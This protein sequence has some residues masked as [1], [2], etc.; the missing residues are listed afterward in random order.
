MSESTKKH[1]AT[2][3]KQLSFAVFVCSTSRYQEAQ[4]REK[5]ADVSGDTIE[6]SLKNAG[7]KVLSRKII[8]DDKSMI[9]EAVHSVLTSAELDAAVFC[10]GTG[11]AQKDIT[12]ETVSPFFE[13]TLPGFGEIFRRLSY[14]K[15]GS[16]AIMSRA[17]AGVAKG[18]VLFCIPGSPDAVRVSV[19]TLILPE[20]SHI[21]R[22]IRE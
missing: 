11:I 16:A 2:A 13:K 4:K 3:P 20:T 1:K 12:I 14:D 22:H 21:V 9:R 17:V 5:T 15:I 7:H 19:E 6:S 10:G 18:K 8:A